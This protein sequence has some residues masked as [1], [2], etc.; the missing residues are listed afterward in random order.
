MTTQNAVPDEFPAVI[1]TIDQ[2]EE[3]ISRPLPGV[4]EE[5]A[6]LDG[7]LMILGV[8]GK[9]GP[10]LAQQ[11][12][13]ALDQI[14]SNY[15]V[16]GVSRFR[17]DGLRQQLESRGIKTIACDLLDR[18]AV[19]ALPDAAATI[20]MAGMKFGSSGAPSMTW[21]MNTHMPSLV[22]DRFQGVPTVVF[23]SGG[24]YPLVSIESA[25]VTEETP[26]DPIG[27]YAQSVLG[28]E[29]IFEH[30]SRQHATKMLQFRLFYAVELR[31]GILYDIASAIWN[32]QSV[33]VSN[34]YA[35]CI[36]QADAN[37][38]AIRCL[39]RVES[40]PSILNA[41]GP[42]RLS[43]RRLAEDFGKLLGKTPEI[44]GTEE[45]T[46]IVADA[47]KAVEIFGPE[48]V[49]LQTLMQWVAHWVKNGGPSLGKPTHFEVRDGKY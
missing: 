41:T 5:L 28:R 38:M 16:I 12:R 40:P 32:G 25:G 30:F 36:W 45:K 49:D 29:R 4:G 23:S 18:K 19:G 39:G 42:R 33:D 22:A 10:S 48:T 21:A 8:G 27:E 3:V 35:N 11:A 6:K 31:Y 34:G 37:A 2:L 17:Q 13:R 24:I 47:S 43:F 26:P 1:E 46:A 15:S 20:F 7:D 44:K 14:G 9:M